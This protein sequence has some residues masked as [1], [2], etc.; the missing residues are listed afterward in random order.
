MDII[1]V[2]I[3]IPLSDDQLLVGLAIMG[4]DKAKRISNFVMRKDRERGILGDLLIR[5]LIGNKFNVSPE[6]IAIVTDLYGKP[7]WNDRRKCDFNISHSG[8]WVVGVLANNCV[9]IDV[10]QIGPMDLSVARHV[11]SEA[12][13][14]ILHKKAG[15][16][17]KDYFYEQWTLK[18]SYIKAIG[19]GFYYSTRDF[20]IN[21]QA[22][23]NQVIDEKQTDLYSLKSYQID[24]NYKLSVCIKG[25]RDLFPNY[26]SIITSENLITDLPWR[27][28]E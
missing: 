13:L 5:Y 21:A 2:N 6:G 7:Y 28:Q 17:A 25:G 23:E 1:A 27:P 16:A 8:D 20:T 19:K 24:P 9:G 11:F 4:E 15:E 14:Q 12:E 22:C 10:E 26:I 18:E 3:T